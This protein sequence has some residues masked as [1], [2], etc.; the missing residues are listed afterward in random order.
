MI[1]LTGFLSPEDL[2]RLTGRAR[3]N[4]QEDWLRT[5]GLPHMRRGSDVLVMCVP[6][7]V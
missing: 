6:V 7:Q 5:E 1:I 4:G 3:A 2:R